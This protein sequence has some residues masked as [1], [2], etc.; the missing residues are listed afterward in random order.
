MHTTCRH[1]FRHIVPLLLN[2]LPLDHLPKFLSRLS[3]STLDVLDPY[4]PNSSIIRC[5]INSP[6]I[7]HI[8]VFIPSIQSLTTSSTIQ[9]SASLLSNFPTNFVLGSPRTQGASTKMT[10]PTATWKKGRL[11]FRLRRWTF[12][13]CH[14]RR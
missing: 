11:R 13:L 10:K 5:R 6:R 7:D 3:L 4:N 14:S 2:R 12:Y 9:L 8:H 1:L